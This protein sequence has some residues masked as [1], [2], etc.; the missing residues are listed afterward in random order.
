M[1]RLPVPGQDES[2]WGTLLNSFLLSELYEDGTLHYD[3]QIV[4]RYDKPASG[5][6]KAHLAN[7]VQSLLNQAQTSVQPSGLMVENLQV[8]VKKTDPTPTTT[9][10]GTRKGLNL[11]SG[12]NL[13]IIV[14]DDPLEGHVSIAVEHSDTGTP[15]MSLQKD[16][17]PTTQHSVLDFE[18]G[19]YVVDDGSNAPPRTRIYVP[20]EYLNVVS[21]PRIGMVPD[22]GD[23]QHAKFQAAVDLA[24]TSQ[25]EACVY[26]PSGLYY[27]DGQITMPNTRSVRLLGSG[28]GDYG[29]GTLIL[30]PTDLGPNQYA[31]KLSSAF[32]W[33]MEQITVAG[34]GN[35]GAHM[36][37]FPVQM[38]G[39]YCPGKGL[40]QQ[41]ECGSFGSSIVVSGVG[42]EW[43]MCYF[44]GSGYGME[45][46]DTPATA[47]EGHLIE[48]VFFTANS[49]A[50]IGI[51]DNASM[52]NVR[53]KGNGHFGTSPFGIHRYANTLGLTRRQQVMNNVV[54]ENYSFEGCGNGNI[55][56]EAG[57][58]LFKNIIF[59]SSGEG[60]YGSGYTWPGKPTN[61]AAIDIGYAENIH[62]RDTDL[63]FNINQLQMRARKFT[64]IISDATT[65]FDYMYYAPVTGSSRPFAIQAGASLDGALNGIS[66]GMVGRN[67][68][69]HA[70]SMAIAAEPIGKYDL[71]ETAGFDRV[72]VSRNGPGSQIIGISAGDCAAGDIC[73]YAVRNASYST[74]IKNKSGTPLLQGSIVKPDPGHPGCGMMA[75]DPSDGPIL[76]R[77]NDGA[78]PNNG[79]GRLMLSIG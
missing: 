42:Q 69:G 5:I 79:S 64:N 39:I 32:P 44:S 74:P 61:L 71:V 30:Y 52:V 57:D 31:F 77:V 12:T 16:D 51:A 78:I 22:V 49:M 50:G 63:G 66:L 2:N 56:D 33:R 20:R 55:Y 29:G 19:S 41:V 4:S 10:V 11:N 17:A 9:T 35:W 6:P 76:G 21:D 43:R 54:F 18:G 8:T 14:T 60:G 28:G 58:G 36:G 53:F 1:V 68:L 23:R 65:T 47:L 38:K 45:W 59:D 3:F 72:R 46:V 70:G 40:M 37:E 67:T 62:W 27:F 75:T 34:P 25:T 7:D 73:V 13:N 15:P 26:I 24:A 48:R